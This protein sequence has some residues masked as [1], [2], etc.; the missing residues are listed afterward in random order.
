MRLALF[1]LALLILGAAP[2]P[3]AVPLGTFKT[4]LGFDRQPLRFVSGGIAV[5]VEALPCSTN[6]N[7]ESTCRWEGYNNQALITVTAPGLPPFRLVSEDQASFVRI[8]VVRFDRR[9]SRP[10]V[11]VDNQWGG[12]AGLTAATVIEPMPGGYR[13]VP[14]ERRAGERLLEGELADNPVDRSGDG[15]VDLVMTDPAFDQAFGCNGC[16]PRPPV[17]LTIRDGKSIDISAEPSVRAVFADD[18]GARRAICLSGQHDRNGNCAAYLADA[19]RLGQFAAAWREMLAH[20]ER[21]C[22][23]TRWQDCRDPGDAHGDRP[24]DA[25]TRF[26][27]FP[28]S[29]RAFLVAAGYITAAQAAAAPTR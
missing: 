2:A 7:P 8:A 13:A 1:A 20:Y 3:P 21:E 29:V 23:W 14:V 25:T 9:S 28:E 11:L 27:G 10:G 4:W 16:T 26:R 5:N 19:A 6:T 15:V 17:V 22:S 24:A 18:L 12:S